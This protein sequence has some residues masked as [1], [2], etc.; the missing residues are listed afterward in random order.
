MRGLMVNW[1]CVFSLWV[2]LEKAD[3]IEEVE[4]VLFLVRLVVLL[5]VLLSGR[6]QIKLGLFSGLG[7]A[8]Y[9]VGIFFATVCKLELND[10]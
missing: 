9:T 6:V 1:R 8:F 5:R 10:V 2:K 4:V 7:V 3:F